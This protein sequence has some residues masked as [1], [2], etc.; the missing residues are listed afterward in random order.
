MSERPSLLERHFRAKL[1]RMYTKSAERQQRAPNALAKAEAKRQRK[2]SKRVRAVASEHEYAE[3]LMGY[4]EKHGVLP[5]HI[6]KA[7]RRI[8]AAC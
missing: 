8:G 6:R 4:V 3:W 2:A 1:T 7:A 5:G